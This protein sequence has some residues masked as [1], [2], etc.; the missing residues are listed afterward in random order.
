MAT[1]ALGSL[2]KGYTT[3]SF[4]T[5]GPLGDQIAG[6]A[7]DALEMAVSELQVN[8]HRVISEL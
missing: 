3:V 2:H 8:D 1:Q 7:V 6:S 4:R 5:C